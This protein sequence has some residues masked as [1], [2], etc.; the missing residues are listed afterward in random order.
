MA[1]VVV[2][3]AGAIGASIVYHLALR[4]ADDVVL[5]DVGEIAGAATGKAMGGVR[6]QFATEAEVRLAQASI[7]LFKELGEP[8]F[9]QVGYLFLA[10]SEE[11]RAELEE[12]RKIQQS[13][14]VPV[15]RV[16]PAFV[17]GLRVDDVLDASICREDGIADPAGVTRE[18]VRRA[19][20]LGVEVRERTDALAVD[21]D[22]LVIACGARSAE[23][24]AARGIELPVRPLV[25]QLADIGPVDALPLHLPMT[26]EE[27]GFHFRRVGTDGL[28]LAMGEPEP[29]W[30]GP[31]TVRDDLVED[32]R[33]R[34]AV[35]YPRAAGAPL[36]RAWAGFYDMTPDAHPIIGSVADGVYAACGFSGHGFMQSPA[37]GD[38][39]AAELL[40]DA[41][42]FDL[43]PY[44]LDR[45]AAGALFPETI[46]L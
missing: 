32:W 29:R 12:R 39:V 5:A 10:T 37:V 24:A 16:D 34:L 36:R 31:E 44:R 1:R 13:L 3:G 20:G 19:A 14:G 46:V 45:F 11:G 18:L 27:N 22:L 26:I 8:L 23:V 9:E 4:G 42:P 28:R 35:R 38:A 43:S 25:R 17:D 40:G 7:R 6:Q 30:D 33:K 15:E 41:A 2:A 21:A